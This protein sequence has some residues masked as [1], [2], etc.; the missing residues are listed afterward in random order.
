MKKMA[1]IGFGVFFLLCCQIGC[2]DKKQE[3]ITSSLGLP[4]PAEIRTQCDEMTGPARVERISERVWVALGFDLA[5]V[6]R[7]RTQ[8]GEVIV[9]AGMSPAKAKEIK[10][11]LEKEVPF[12]PVKALIYTHSHIDHVGGASVWVEEGTEIWAVEGFTQHLMKQYGLFREAESKRGLRQFGVRVHQE[13]LPCSAIGPRPDMQAMDKSGVLFPTHSFR[14]WKDIQ[15]GG[16]RLCLVEAPGETHDHLFIWIPQEQTLLCGDNFYWSFPNLYT[17]RG[18]S[19]RPVDDWIRSLDRMRSLS[20]QHLVPGHTRPIHGPE[21]ISRVLRDYRDAIQ[22]VRDEVVRGANLGLDL[23]TLAEAVRLPPHL[24][25]QPQ[26]KELYGQVDWSVRAFYTNHLGWFDGRAHRIYPLEHKEA[27]RREVQLLGGPEKLISLASEALQGGDPRWATHLLSKLEDSG[28]AQGKTLHG[29]KELLAASYET[30]AQEISNTNGRGYLLESVQ[31]LRHGPLKPSTPS[32][33]PRFLERIPL[34]HIFSLMSTRIAP[35]ETMD[36][37]ECMVFS[38]PDEAASF[39]LTLRRG[40]LEVW[41]GEPLPG[42]P[43][44]VAVLTMD[45]VEFRRMLFRL[46]NPLALYLEGKI[47]VQGN[48]LKALAFLRRFRLAG[49]KQG[50]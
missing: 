13:D 32:A 50:N 28:L 4:S 19:P 46:A 40:L 27:A 39:N 17:L 2:K 29:L 20:P 45:S 8:E 47:N 3:V 9:D 30:L 38:F 5:N 23:D 41:E 34:E 15:I 22:W 44:P 25:N 42:T 36:L 21:E 14:G 35:K 6:A 26:N 10:T 37:E 18:T 33:D 7:I 11:A 12:G 1:L 24:L 16:I 31:E 43:E 49:E 48:W